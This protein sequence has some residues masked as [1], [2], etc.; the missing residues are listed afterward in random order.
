MLRAL[1][2]Q[3]E[4]IFHAEPTMDGVRHDWRNQVP[5]IRP[6]LQNAQARETGISKQDL[7][8]ALLINFSGKQIGLYRETSHLLPIVARA[9]AEERLQADS[10]WKLQI[11]STEHNTF[12]ASHPSGEPVR[13]PVGK[14]ASEASRP[15]ADVSCFGRSKA[16]Q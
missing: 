14:P 5:L 1:G 8:N 13:N 11:W 9:P 7:D 3:A 4:A 2:A 16:W 15:D 12:R 6:Q 10:L